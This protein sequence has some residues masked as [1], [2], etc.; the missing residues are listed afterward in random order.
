MG[1]ASLTTCLEV[2][3]SEKRAQRADHACDRCSRPTLLGRHR[4]EAATYCPFATSEMRPAQG[5]E[6]PGFDIREI[7]AT[8]FGV[9]SLVHD[10]QGSTRLCGWEP[11]AS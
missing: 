10:T 3:K 9:D 2:A 7:H 1:G 6:N 4:G 5:C 8:H 11:W